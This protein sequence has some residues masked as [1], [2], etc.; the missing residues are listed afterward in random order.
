MCE[1]RSGKAWKKC[2]KAH[3]EK[4]IKPSTETLCRGTGPAWGAPLVGRGTTV[5]ET[6]GTHAEPAGAWGVPPSDPGS[7]WSVG[8]V[9]RG[10]EEETFQEVVCPVGQVG[11][12]GPW[13]SQCGRGRRGWEV[14][15]R[16][17]RTHCSRT[18]PAAERRETCQTVEHW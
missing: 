2:K 7:C 17:W 16:L 9:L 4:I 13:R 12:S 6:Q 3:L 1:V 14:R 11:Q 10:W 18:R 5:S 15:G 8:R